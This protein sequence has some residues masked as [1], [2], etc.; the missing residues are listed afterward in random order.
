MNSTSQKLF[1]FLSLLL[2]HMPPIYAQ[3]NWEHTDGPVGSSS[4]KIY[5]NEQYAF[6]PAGDFLFR[7]EDGNHWEKINHP[8][9]HLLAIY[10]NTLVSPFWDD[11]L[12]RMKLFISPD[13]GNTWIEK[14]LP[15]AIKHY[16]AIAMVSHGIYLVQGSHEIIYRSID[17]GDTWS[18]IPAPLPFA[19]EVFA[20]DERLYLRSTASVTRSDKH[21]ENWEPLLLPHEPFSDPIGDIVATNEHIIISGSSRIYDSH[22]HGNTWNQYTTESTSARIPL[23]MNGSDIYAMIGSKLLRSQDFGISWVSASSANEQIIPVGFTAFQH[24]VLLTAYN[25]GIFKWE[26]TD[27]E[28]VES[29]EG[30]GKG[31]VYDLALEGETIYAA[32]GNGLFTYEFSEE[33]WAENFFLPRPDDQYDYVSTNEHG[34]ICTGTKNKNYYFFSED[35]GLTWDSISY[36]STLSKIKDINLIGSTILLCNGSQVFSSVDK[37]QHWTF[38][39]MSYHLS[40]SEFVHFQGK[41]YILNSI[42]ELYHTSDD[43]VTWVPDSLSVRVRSLFSSHNHDRFFGFVNDSANTNS[44]Y[45]SDNGQD[46]ISAQTGFPKFLPSQLKNKGNW[47]FYQEDQTYFAFLGEYGHFISTDDCLTWNQLPTSQTG[48]DYLAYD[49][50]IYLGKEGVYKSPFDTSTP[51]ENNIPD[52]TELDWLHYYPNP[53]HDVLILKLHDVHFTNSNLEYRMFNSLGH[54]IRKGTAQIAPSFEIDMKDLLPGIY[55]IQV[56]MEDQMDVFKVIKQ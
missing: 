37:G 44:L 1:I 38:T 54:L 28:F 27:G 34:W 25:K 10:Q 50:T 43:G 33:A 36:G 14:Y 20:C 24:M 32:C 49:N 12:Q 48:N 3:L 55:F 2:M 19:F 15:E 35:A 22:D 47:L 16:G 23:T 17:L 51:V 46:W 30:F 26:E 13:N 31:Y 52:A 5:S 7:S 56:A 39:E 6:I 42:D 21:G 4:T 8:V 45:F 40:G 9:S 29:N 11:T 18:T 53:F 41:Q